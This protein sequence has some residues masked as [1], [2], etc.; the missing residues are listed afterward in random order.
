VRRV[1]YAVAASLDG[2]IAGPQGEAEWIILDPQIDFGKMFKEFDTVLLG[3]RTFEAMANKGTRSIPGMQTFVFS[4]TLRQRDH[5]EVTIVA[6]QAEQILSTIR[7]E[8]GKDIWLMGGGTLFRSLLEAGLVDTVEISVV[9]VL[10]GAGIPL[11][12]SPASQAKLELVRH[13]VYGTGIVSLRYVVKPD[14]SS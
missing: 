7:R 9:P 2:Y 10:L 3:R 12:P 13:T 14:K 4:R 11:L 8:P 1:R 5:P 6:D